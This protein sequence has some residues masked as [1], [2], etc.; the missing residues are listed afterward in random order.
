MKDLA[1]A[2][3]LLQ[4]TMTSLE[5]AELTGKKHRNVLRDIRVIIDSQAIGADLHT[6]F[7]QDFYSDS[8]GRH[9][10][11]YAMNREATLLLITGYDMN[12][13]WK[14][15]SR[16]KELESESLISKDS[17]SKFGL[18]LIKSMKLDKLN[19]LK[20]MDL[21]GFYTGNTKSDIE[22]QLAITDDDDEIRPVK[23]EDRITSAALG[24][25]FNMNIGEIKRELASLGLIDNN[26]HGI[27]LTELGKLYG[28][29]TS[30]YQIYWHPEVIRMFNYD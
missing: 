5:V 23:W 7:T 14:L 25:M 20:A 12:A 16:W 10:P 28:K 19:R 15:I 30:K 1:V 17:L 4:Q 22:H 8:Y 27:E 6:F 21:L 26:Y 2:L 13:R 11:C 18:E 24:R 29:Y 3:Q 9:Q